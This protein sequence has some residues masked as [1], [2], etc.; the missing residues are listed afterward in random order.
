MGSDD[1]APPPAVSAHRPRLPRLPPK[2]LISSP[3]P[4]RFHPAYSIIAYLIRIYT[5]STGAQLPRLNDLPSFT[6]RELDASN[7]VLVPLVPLENPSG[8]SMQPALA[9]APHPSMQTSAQVSS[10]SNT[11]LSS[12]SSMARVARWST[13]MR[14]ALQEV[15][16]GRAVC[17][18]A[19]PPRASSRV[20]R[21]PTSCPELAMRRLT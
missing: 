18:R 14:D 6:V 3:P 8:P 5:S 20:F 9:P 21:S 16:L 7:T 10:P 11:R 15:G 13:A 2:S 1:S 12:R 17:S 19:K 4:P